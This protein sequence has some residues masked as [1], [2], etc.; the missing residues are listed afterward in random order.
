MALGSALLAAAL[1]AG[2]TPSP[3]TAARLS[4]TGSIDASRQAGATLE[5]LS[6]PTQ[7]QRIP[8]TAQIVRIT[9]VAPFG[10][11]RRRASIPPILI[12]D[13]SKVRAIAKAIDALPRLQPGAYSCPSDN[14]SSISFTFRA[15]EGG[16]ALARVKAEPTGCG[17]V[18][19]WIGQRSEPALTDGY[20]LVRRVKKLLGPAGGRLP[21]PL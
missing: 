8:P 6:L 18:E 11:R 2:S 12:T 19:V 4:N 20:R 7:A 1:L 10:D 3:G 21:R 5:D 15:F 17:T 14:G 16:P 13:F 9:A